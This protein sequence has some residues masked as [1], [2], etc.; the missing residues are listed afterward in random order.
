MIDLQREK[1]PLTANATVEGAAT[2]PMVYSLR[3]EECKNRKQV[4]LPDL[5]QESINKMPAYLASN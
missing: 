3:I 5:L 4:Y 2:A 1:D